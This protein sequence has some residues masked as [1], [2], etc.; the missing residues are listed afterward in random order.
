[1]QFQSKSQQDFSVDTEEVVIKF[2]CKNKETRIVRIILEKNE[3]EGLWLNFK[4]HY[5]ATEIN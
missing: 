5:K 3:V 4:T 2:K 1:M